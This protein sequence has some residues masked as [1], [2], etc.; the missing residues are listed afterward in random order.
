MKIKKAIEYVD[1]EIEKKKK[2]SINIKPNEFQDLF[3]YLQNEAESS[4]DIYMKK[5][6]SQLTFKN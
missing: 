6:K 3:D 2:K 5:D 4:I 1:Q